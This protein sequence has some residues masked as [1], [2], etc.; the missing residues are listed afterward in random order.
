MNGRTNS[1]STGD[2]AIVEIP[3]DPPVILDA[4][5]G[6]A[7]VLLT[8]EDPKNK[9]ATPEGEQMEDTDQLVSIWTNTVVV[10]KANSAPVNILDG[11]T[12]TS[13]GSRDQYKTD[14]FI[15]DT[16]TNDTLYYYGLFGINEN[17]VPSEPAIVS[18]LPRIGTPASE[19]PVGTII[20]INENGTPYEYTII[21]QG[22]PNSDL[23]DETC[24]GTWVLRKTQVGTNRW[25]TEG[26]TGHFVESNIFNWLNSTMLN[27]YSTWLQNHIIQ[28]NI[29]VERYAY[30]GSSDIIYTNS[31]LFLLSIH[32]IGHGGPSNNYPNAYV[33]DGTKLDYFGA[34]NISNNLVYETDDYKQKIVSSGIRGWTRSLVI[35]SYM[36]HGSPKNVYHVN[37]TD[38]N[39]YYSTN[40]TWME[41]AQHSCPAFIIPSN[42]FIDGYLNLIEDY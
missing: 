15:D 19:L 24:N 7:R 1:T 25:G 3:L 30:Y 6:N 9:Y 13:S 2:S 8:W 41:Y 11:T 33:Q 16:V 17:G 4:I 23:Y 5:P 38:N 22:K 28:S 31:K 32:E 42:S 40:G 39:E 12:I 27:R 20:K 29:P 34:C 18:V 37:I 14:P 35:S 21:H 26:S 36:G 10:R